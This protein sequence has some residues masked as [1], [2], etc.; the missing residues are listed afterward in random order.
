MQ[1]YPSLLEYTITSLENKIRYIQEN[2]NKIKIATNANHYLPIHLDF[3]MQNFAKERSILMSLEF[4][5]VWNTLIKLLESENILVTAH[6]M[7]ELEDVV[8]LRNEFETYIIPNKWKSE[9]YLPSKYYQGFSKSRNLKKFNFYPY[10]DLNDWYL[11]ENTFSIDPLVS[12]ALI[13]TVKGGLSGQILTDEVK[14]A[15]LKIVK[16]NHNIQFILDGGWKIDSDFGGLHNLNLV[17]N[18]SFWKYF[19]FN[20]NN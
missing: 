20:S 10:F 5:T 18:T 15:S 11:S 14:Q 17:S 1:I 7:G 4:K 13:L 9:F 6:F 16:N 12:K 2:I 3:V 19:G 8:L